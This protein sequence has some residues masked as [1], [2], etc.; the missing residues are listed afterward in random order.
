M[1][2]KQPGSADRFPGEPGIETRGRP[3]FVAEDESTRWLFA[4]NRMGIRPGLQRIRGLLEDLG[5]PEESL[6]TLVVAGTNG[7]GTATRALAAMLQAGG[8]RTACYTSPHLLRVYERLTIDGIPVDPRLFAATVDRVR[9]L[10]EKHQASWFETLTAVALEIAR[11]SGVEAFCCE[12]GLGGRLDASN[13]LPAEAL[14]LTGVSLDHTHIL[15]GT[16]EQILA[17]KLGLLKPGA[18]LFAAVADDLRARTFAAAVESGSPC[19]FLDELA[20]VEDR[21][22]VWDLALRDRVIS[23]LPALP[24][25]PLRRSVALAVM[26]LAELEREGGFG[27]P[28]DP[29]AALA[30]LFLPGRF[31]RVLVE[32]DWIFDTAHNDEALGGA[33]AGFLDG[34][35]RGRR[36]V[37]FG[38]MQDKK[39]DAK[40][41]GA[42]AR[43]DMVVAAPVSLPRSRNSEDLE[44]L[45][46]EWG[47]AEATETLVAADAGDAVGRL[48][49]VL[50][51]RDSVLVTGSCFM[52]AEVMHRLGF[53]DLEETRTVRPA[54]EAMAAAAGGAEEDHTGGGR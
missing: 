36:V 15:G 1:D 53:R 44:A 2:R 21:G 27:L 25:A 13:A 10:T 33:L 40:V 51:P 45:L 50:E 34:E 7:K 39:L 18:P 47:V 5:H 30:G 26:A 24:A 9:P 32:P 22:P 43:A 41:G 52:V 49:A 17:E 42:L 37:L 6:R 4:L 35:S 8:H 38:G 23:G 28:D 48:A 54:R 31:H 12:T 11:E 20:R 19:L 14:L 3:P 16:R 46:R 29:A